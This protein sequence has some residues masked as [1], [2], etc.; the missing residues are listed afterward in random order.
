M[1]KLGNS[2]SGEPVYEE[3]I[4]I[5]QERPKITNGVLVSPCFVDWRTAGQKDIIIGNA[6]GGLSLF[7]SR[8]NEYFGQF[9]NMKHNNK[10]IKIKAGLN[11]SIQGPHERNWGYLGVC[12][13]DFNKDGWIDL[14]VC[15]I[16]GNHRMYINN[17]GKSTFSDVFYIKTKGQNLKTVWRCKPAVYKDSSDIIRYVCLDEDG[18]L[19]YYEQI[20][21][22]IPYE[23]SE[24]HYIYYDDGNKIKLDNYY[25]LS[26]RIKLDFCHWY[27]CNDIV[28]G[29]KGNQNQAFNT[30]KGSILFIMKNVGDIDNLIYEYPLP[31]RDH[32]GKLLKF[33]DHECSPQLIDLNGDGVEELVVGGENGAIN[34]FNYSYLFEELLVQE[35][36]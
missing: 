23:F 3:P 4:R 31:L 8:G 19:V 15:D 30:Y 9:E 29:T 26:G 14:A 34:I 24:K 22:A 7:P 21:S 16:K 13:F 20:S 5:L 2:R 18:F 27:G 36:T 12:S 25:G 32:S 35:L 1:K 6:A 17:R 28:F 33:G 11:G 10:D